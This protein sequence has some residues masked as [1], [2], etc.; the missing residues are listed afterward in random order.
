MSGSSDEPSTTLAPEDA[1]ARRRLPPWYPRA[2]LVAIGLLLA[3]AAAVLVA[4]KLRDVIQILLITFFFAV[5]LEPLVEFLVRHGWRRGAAS[6][7]VLGGLLIVLVLLGLIVLLPLLRQL[8]GLIDDIPALLQALGDRTDLNL[9][10]SGTAQTLQ[11]SRDQLAG[12][13]DA[14]AGGLI[15][16]TSAMGALLFSFFTVLLL[17]FYVLAEGPRFRRAVCSVITPRR[18]DEFLRIWSISVDKM[19]GYLY[20]KLLLAIPNGLTAFLTLRLLGVPFAVPLALWQAFVSGFVPIVGTY[21]G[22]AVPAIVALATKGWTAGIVMVVVATVYQQIENYLFSPKISQRTMELHPAVA[23]LAALVGGRLGGLFGAF[24]ALP[25]AAI[26]QA[27]ASTI[28]AR[29]EVAPSQLTAEDDVASARARHALV[30]AA[31]SAMS[32]RLR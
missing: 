29:Y 19:G 17:T 1:G 9:S 27:F 6:G 21:L 31:R 13:A 16:V 4:I 12:V 7:G 14:L 11:G 15:A 30:K 3:A 5:A 20:S 25:I 32:G 10:G 28:V 24:L 23:F 8:V 22:V 2:V 26:V 18:Q